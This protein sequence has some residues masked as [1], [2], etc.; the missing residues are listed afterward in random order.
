MGILI[1]TT[2][3]NA[4]YFI[5]LSLAGIMCS[6][7]IYLRTNPPLSR[8]GRIFLAILRTMTI[9]LIIALIFDPV[10]N[11]STEHVKKPTLTVMIDNSRS[12]S[13]KD[14]AYKRSEKVRELLNAEPLHELF[15]R[16][17]V[18]F[19]AFSNRVSEIEPAKTDSLQFN[20]EGTD[21][22]RALETIQKEN[23]TKAAL[24]VTDGIYTV[25]KNPENVSAGLNVPVYVIAVGDSSPRKDVILSNLQYNNIGY[26]DNPVSIDAYVKSF[27]A[28]GTST[29]IILKKKGKVLD[30]RR[31]TLPDDYLE[32][33]E[34]FNLVPDSIGLNE[35]E[36][37]INPQEGELTTENNSKSFIIKVL[38]SKY[39]ILIVAGKPGPDFSFIKRALK[40]NK[41]FIVD[42]LAEK[43]GGSFYYNNEE[44]ILNNLS[45]FDAFIFINFPDEDSKNGFVQRVKNEITNRNVPFLYLIGKGLSSNAIGRF[46]Q[47][48]PFSAAGTSGKEVEAFGVLTEEGLKHPALRLDDDLSENL[49]KW[50]KFPPVFTSSEFIRI[51]K[52]CTILMKTEK[53]TAHN[54]VLSEKIPLIFTSKNNNIKSLI[55]NGYGIW[56]WKLTL[57]DESNLQNAF[58]RLINNSTRWL[59]TKEEEKPVRIYTHKEFFSSGEDV[60]IN[61][62]VYNENYEPVDGAEVRVEITGDDF[63]TEKLLRNTGDGKYTEILEILEAGT[64]Q[65]SGTAY[66]KKRLLGSDRGNFIIG[67]FSKEL[68]NTEM[69]IGLLRTIADNT[70][71]K[72]YFPGNLSTMAQDINIF[73]EEYKETREFAFWD[74]KLTLILIAFFFTV[75]LFF[76][77]RWGLL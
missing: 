62:E 70:N 74:K 39:R 48:L 34:T 3:G 53:K 75:E 14:A 36:I 15:S 40:R 49:G 61:A 45:S 26:L 69:D 60:N 50:D 28:S 5:L 46:R 16:Y 55:I 20:E 12:M 59:I 23:E 41:K 33:K 21:I 65:F 22:A 10:L 68:L 29:K 35:Y 38:K 4:I 71:G 47:L 6:A 25:G 11:Y 72:V 32:Q 44:E 66:Y 2:T 56:R 37:T 24:L 77:K 54:V 42:D 76:R 27:G 8:G 31:I 63:M 9:L 43:K 58:D 18:R 67:Q 17:N 19:A 7:W 64:Y 51:G 13:I 57:T 52:T 73:G 1:L 30:S